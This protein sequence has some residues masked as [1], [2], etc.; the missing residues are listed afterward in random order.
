MRSHPART[1]PTPLWV[2]LSLCLSVQADYITDRRAAEK[3]VRAE[4][5]PEAMA[6]FVEMAGAADSDAQRS[7]ALE[8]AAMCAQKLGT[9]DRAME[10]AERIPLAPASR[11]VRMRLMLQNGKHAELI[12]AF[13]DDE[14]GR[15]PDKVAGEAFY[16]RGRAYV[17]LKDGKAAES[18]LRKALKH[19]ADESAIARAWLTLADNYRDN[20]RDDESALEAY[21][22]VREVG[23]ARDRY[24][25]KYL[26]SLT[27]AADVLRRQGRHDEAFDVLK[28]ADLDGLRGYWRGAML[29]AYGQTLAAQG[30]TSEAIAKLRDALEREDVPPAQ[31]DACRQTMREIR[32]QTR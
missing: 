27:S 19:L 13:G 12:A 8:Q 29:H 10:L 31:K 15:W 9:Y 20:L 32:K 2:L 25:W 7:D 14:A 24:G 17:T 3:L 5:W 22:R 21:A 16:C 26:S 11:T 4:Q 18:Q 1:R 23:G 30:K 6:A 28:R